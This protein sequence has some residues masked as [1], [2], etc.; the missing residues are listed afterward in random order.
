MMVSLIERAYP[1][2]TCAGN[3]YKTFYH[4]ESADYNFI[5]VLSP[6]K[7]DLMEIPP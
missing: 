6:R 2:N 3:R 4:T 5:N 1:L 7:T